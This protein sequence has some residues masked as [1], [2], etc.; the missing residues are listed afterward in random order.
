L[1]RCWR[2]LRRMEHP[3]SA[4]SNLLRAFGRGILTQNA[5]NSLHQRCSILPCNVQDQQPELIS[6][7]PRYKII[8]PNSASQF[9]ADRPQ[10]GVANQ[11]S[12]FVV[13]S[14]EV[15]DVE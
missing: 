14:F 7:N 6:S 5:L 13:D 8:G 12:M 15:I 4:Y 2:I 10:H 3:A 1:G 11:V 9:A